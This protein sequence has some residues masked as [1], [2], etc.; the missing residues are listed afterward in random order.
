MFDF[1]FEL[2]LIEG[3]HSWQDRLPQHQ[4]HGN[5]VRKG[6]REHIHVLAITENWGER[7]ETVV[8]F[9]LA[10]LRTD[11]GMIWILS[12]PLGGKTCCWHWHLGTLC[13]R[14][15]HRRWIL[16]S[17]LWRCLS[18]F[19]WYRAANLLCP[20]LFALTTPTCKAFTRPYL[21]KQ[22]HQNHHHNQYNVHHHHHTQSF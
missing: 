18:T 7:P 1:L 5:C 4:P 20:S 10:D 15:Q 19:L 14:S 3:T 16:T 2:F 22:P 12:E 8:N 21:C 11:L 9:Y 13:T 17:F 6:G